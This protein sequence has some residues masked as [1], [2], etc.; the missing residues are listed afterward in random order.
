MKYKKGQWERNKNR[1][2]EKGKI[3]TKQDINERRRND[4]K[5]NAFLRE[6]ESSNFTTVISSYRHP[7]CKSNLI[8]S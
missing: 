5:T 1:E 3:E 4:I 8:S 6:R 2:K 7:H